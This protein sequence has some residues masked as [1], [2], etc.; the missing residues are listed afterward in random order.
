MQGYIKYFN[1]KHFL[2]YTV[3]DSETGEDKN[4]NI[5][6]TSAKRDYILK[7]NSGLH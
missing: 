5:L 7:M 4:V 2:N 3:K 6:G 1:F